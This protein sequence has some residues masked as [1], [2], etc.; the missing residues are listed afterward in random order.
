[1]EQILYQDETTID[2]LVWLGAYRADRAKHL[3]RMVR[4]QAG[5]KERGYFTNVRD[6]GLLS[7]VA[8][9][10]LY[11]RRWDIELAVKL[12]K[13]DLGLHLLWP[14]KSSVITHQIWA[15]LLIAQMLQALRVEIAVRAEVDPY[16]VS[17][18]LMI[19]HYPEYA[20]R[21]AD[22]IAEFVTDGRRL[23]FIRPSSRIHARAPTI[24]REH[25][26]MPRPDLRTEQT[27]RYA[28][29]IG[30]KHRTPK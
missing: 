23:G 2:Q 22:P 21:F 1:M 17:M 26:T 18:Q 16:E 28:N 20:A 14:A 15:V 29:K 9:T 25:I 7:L 19:R 3:V 11:A 5:G 4:F 12:V 10:E 24:P 8:I 13:R 30:G 27:P 6:P